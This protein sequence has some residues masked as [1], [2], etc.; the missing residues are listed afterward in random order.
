MPNVKLLAEKYNEVLNPTAEQLIENVSP[1]ELVECFSALS[2]TD[3]HSVLVSFE[4]AIRA[5]ERGVSMIQES[6]KFEDQELRLAILA[7]EKVLAHY[8]KTQDEEYCVMFENFISGKSL[9]EAAPA[10]QKQGFMSKLGQ[11][12]KKYAGKAATAIGNGLKAAPGA[13]AKGAAAT[14]KYVGQTVGGAVGG[15]AGGLVGG[16]QGAYNNA[17]NTAPYMNQQGGNETSAI[18]GNH[19]NYQQPDANTPPQQGGGNPAPAANTPPQQG[20][21]NPAPATPGKIT[22]GQITAAVKALNAR[23]AKSV[24][25]TIQARLTQLGV[26]PDQA[27]GT[28]APGATNQG[29]GSGAPNNN[30]KGDM[31]VNN[32]KANDANAHPW[33]G[34]NG[35]AT[36]KNVIK[37]Y[38][39]I[40]NKHFRK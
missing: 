2:R 22:T 6:V 39:I 18:Y 29:P 31:P 12:I 35:L 26:K 16:A 30:P 32:P 17:R 9:N 37:E 38:Y 19:P 5:R 28:N 14:G 27:P 36:E 25:K 13:I 34:S 11:G 24:L 3:E 4:H 23:D 20:G 10:P 33:A 7:L 15:L 40:N 8:D 1:A 21:G